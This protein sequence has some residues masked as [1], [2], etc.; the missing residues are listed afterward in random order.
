MSEAVITRGAAETYF[1]RNSGSWSW[2]FFFLSED[3]ISIQ[4]DFGSYGYC[5]QHR[6]EETLKQFLVGCDNSYL[7]GKFTMGQPKHFDSDKTIELIRKDIDAGL[8]EGSLQLDPEHAVY[9][10]VEELESCSTEVEFCMT[11]DAECRDL[12]ETVYGGDITSVPL[13]KTHP[14]D[15][16][17]FMENIWPIFR[18][19]LKKELG[20]D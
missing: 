6:G 18:A 3:F 19:E 1:I 9:R 12:V 5:W 2:A 10:D 16:V 4:S 13:V 11:L 15:L 20:L 8:R 7:M 14:Q 17:L